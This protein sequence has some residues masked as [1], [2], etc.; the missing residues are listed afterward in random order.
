[1]PSSHRMIRMTAIVSSI[2]RRLLRASRGALAGLSSNRC[3]TSPSVGRRALV[4]VLHVVAVVMTT[5]E[6]GRAQDTVEQP[7]TTSEQSAT[8]RTLSFLGGGLVG[9][10]AHET[11][12]LIFDTVFDAHATV[13]RVSFHGVPF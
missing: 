10:A 9:L 3:A 13:K 8:A 6:V 5:A 11:G 2:V 4:V 1:M 12:H 7:A